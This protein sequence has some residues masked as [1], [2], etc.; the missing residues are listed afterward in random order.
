MTQT[1]LLVTVLGLLGA[2]FILWSFI[3][4]LARKMSPGSVL[5]LLLNFFGGILV[6]I[7]SFWYEAYPALIINVVWVA[8]SMWGLIKLY[9]KGRELRS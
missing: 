6:A 1:E 5:Y 8:A 2:G 4:N 3:A 9:S 7:N